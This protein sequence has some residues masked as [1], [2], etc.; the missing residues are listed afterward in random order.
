[1]KNS[2]IIL[3]IS[4][5]TI[6]C[7]DPDFTTLLKSGG[8]GPA[9]D[10][11]DQASVWSYRMGYHYVHLTRAFIYDENLISVIQRDQHCVVQANNLASGDS[12]WTQASLGDCNPYRVNN[13][14]VEGDI[15]VLSD[16]S[17]MAAVSMKT[18]EL[19]WTDTTK[20][21][22]G[23]I[24]IIDG[25]VIKTA[26]G[27]EYSSV[28]AIDIFTGD[29]RE[30]YREVISPI[31]KFG[32][33]YFS[34]KKYVNTNGQD[35][36]LFYGR[37]VREGNTN[38]RL[39]ALAYN[40]TLNTVEWKR[41]LRDDFQCTKISIVDDRAYLIGTDYLLCVSTKNGSTIWQRS[42]ENRSDDFIIKDERIFV[43]SGAIFNMN[44]GAKVGDIDNIR[45]DN[46]MTIA[47]N[48]IFSCSYDLRVINTETLELTRYGERYSRYVVP[49]PTENWVYLTK[50]N[51]I[52]CLNLDLIL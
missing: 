40:L 38:S 37:S 48:K 34:P 28:Y 27:L 33:G 1:M 8:G 13:C 16:A 42:V 36:L 41:T 47:Q 30:I 10:P 12:I 26:S 22:E 45:L 39:L 32:S 50:G 7:G 5:F 18:G 19:L 29:K 3:L 52:F 25:M 49:H 14:Q 46:G 21:G 2:I 15:L 17:R 24:S 44:S 51:S 20:D 35:I 23:E 4:F 31:F 43:S 9:A 11:T 6:S